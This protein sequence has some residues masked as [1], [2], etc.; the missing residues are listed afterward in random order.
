MT[1]EECPFRSSRVLHDDK[2]EFHL[3]N[4][5]GGDCECIPSGCPYL[6]AKNSKLN[7][8][9]LP[10]YVQID[11]E[12]GVC[13]D[14]LQVQETCKENQDSFT[15][16]EEAAKEYMKKARKHLFDDSP[17]GRADDA[18][19]AGAEW[20]KGQDEPYMKRNNLELSLMLENARK[21]GILEGKAEMMK[22][23]VEAEI[24]VGR[25][26]EDWSLAYNPDGLHNALRKFKSGDKVKI[27]IVE[28]D[29]KDKQE[30][31]P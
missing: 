28:Q 17:I 13:I 26:P 31:H 19:I 3:C 12:Q 25:L 4:R 1:Q 5:E 29:G 8:P 10:G 20:Q 6:I 15:S 16:L 27:I 2:G 23:A 7:L 14:S 11:N 30:I 9:D 21:S 18:F 22:D 24:T